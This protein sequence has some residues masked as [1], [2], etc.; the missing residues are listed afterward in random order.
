MALLKAV[1]LVLPLSVI[2]EVMFWNKLWGR[3]SLT[4]YNE[5]KNDENI[6]LFGVYLAIFGAKNRIIG[7]LRFPQFECSFGGLD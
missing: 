5:R 4:S 2:I 7:A 1:I 3:A 6:G